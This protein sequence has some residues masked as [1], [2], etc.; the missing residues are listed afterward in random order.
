MV[1]YAETNK[2]LALEPEAVKKVSENS[3]VAAMF[4]ETGTSKSR[5]PLAPS[6]RFGPY[7]VR[8]DHQTVPEMSPFLNQ[9]L[10]RSPR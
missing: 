9:V 6:S 5:L 2:P 10:I 1:S 8:R 4:Y 3:P 7:P